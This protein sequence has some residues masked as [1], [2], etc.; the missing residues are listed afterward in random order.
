ME[1]PLIDEVMNL[2]RSTGLSTLANKRPANYPEEYFARW[3][4]SS[5]CTHTNVSAVL[6]RACVH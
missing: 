3:T 4:V 1:Y 5:V 6:W 2:C